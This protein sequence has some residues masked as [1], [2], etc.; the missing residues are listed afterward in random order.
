MCWELA[1][2]NRTRAHGPQKTDNPRAGKLPGKSRSLADTHAILL[3]RW[4]L[5]APFHTRRAT[6][7]KLVRGHSTLV[8]PP[9]RDSCITYL[10]AGNASREEE[11]ERVGAAEGSE[12]LR[13]VLVC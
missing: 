6:S 13:P 4:R 9:V 2:G 10:A 1:L 7:G 8:T 5:R 12:L 11:T 3:L